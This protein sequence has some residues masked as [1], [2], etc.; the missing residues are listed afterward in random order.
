[1]HTRYLQQAAWTRQIRSY[2]FQQAGLQT[3][4]HVLEVGCGTGAVLSDPAAAGPAA[5]ASTQQFYGID[6]SADALAQCRVNASSATLARA[7]ALAL[8]YA[9]AVFDI[10]YCHFVLLWVKD[11]VGVLRE[12]KRVTRGHVLALAEPDYSGRIDRPDE[13]APLGQLQTQ[14]LRD[15][16]ADVSLGSRLADLFEAAGIRASE[17]GIIRPW[18]QAVSAPADLEAEWNM[19]QQDIGNRLSEVDLRRDIAVSMSA[20][21]SPESASCTFRRTLLGVRYNAVEPSGRL[22]WKAL[23]ICPPKSQRCN[24]PRRLRGGAICLI[25]WKRLYWPSFCSWP[26]TRFPPVCAWMD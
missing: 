13:L 19:L 16:G 18:T 22:T 12:M 21:V 4:Q 8:P 7:D 2:L 9:D 3:A 15:Q 6:L 26:S 17:A 14:S 25:C 23:Q 11:P 10:T 20:L 1:M 24:K 5:R